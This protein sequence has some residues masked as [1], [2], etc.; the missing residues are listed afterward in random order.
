M[1]VLFFCFFQ[2]TD[3]TQHAAEIRV[4]NYPLVITNAF[5]PRHRDGFEDFPPFV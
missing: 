5:P 2:T 1:H 4:R 3:H